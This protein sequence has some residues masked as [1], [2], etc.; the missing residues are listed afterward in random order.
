MIHSE[1]RVDIVNGTQM[2]PETKA[3]SGMTRQFLWKKMD[4]IAAAMQGMI[5]NVKAV[6]VNRI[7]QSEMTWL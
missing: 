2:I 3:I 5:A 1:K 4:Y 7:C 6:L